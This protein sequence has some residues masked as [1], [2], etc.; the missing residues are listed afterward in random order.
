[1]CE[2][3]IEDCLIQMLEAGE[4][5]IGFFANFGG[6]EVP[7]QEVPLNELATKTELES[8][9]PEVLVA[10]LLEARLAP[11]ITQPDA[12]TL[13]AIAV[14]SVLAPVLQQAQSDLPAELAW[15]FTQQFLGAE[16]DSWD[17]VVS[18]T[19]IAWA[20]SELDD[21]LQVRYQPY[22]AI[23][24]IEDCVPKEFL[25]A[26]ELIRVP[27]TLLALILLARSQP[28]SS[29]IMRFVLARPIKGNGFNGIELWLQRRAF[30]YALK[31]HGM[32]F[33]VRYMQ[34]C[35]ALNTPRHRGF[36]RPALVCY[37]LTRSKLSSAQATELLEA[38]APYQRLGEST[39][40]Y[41]NTINDW[42][43]NRSSTCAANSTSS[44]PL[45]T[46]PSA[47]HC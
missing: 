18:E 12:E 20:H 9:S 33:L 16:E 43:Q 13:Q 46:K 32:S 31:I 15:L 44:A 29:L 2:Y 22:A 8:W 11:S 19:A 41:R 3:C 34:S 26:D 24:D 25:T 35:D 6:S 30:D 28:D 4:D 27:Q 7:A 39:A 37:G 21:A 45:E 10:R 38:L 42:L 40:F 14:L 36:G 47:N 17:M 5:I 23:D 1:M